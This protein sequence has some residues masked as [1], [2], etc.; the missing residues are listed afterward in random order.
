MVRNF[1]VRIG[2]TISEFFHKPVRVFVICTVLVVFGLLLDG[3]LLRLWRLNRDSND[4]GHRIH[5]LEIQSKV[6]DQKIQRAKDPAFIELE[7]REK[8]DLAGEGDLVFV[9]AD[10]E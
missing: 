3:S 1:F 10:E 7:A 4:L 8:L 5:E 6:I 9:F 2:I